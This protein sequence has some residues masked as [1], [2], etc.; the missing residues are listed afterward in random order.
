MGTFWIQKI[1]LRQFLC[2]SMWQQLK[3]QTSRAFFVCFEVF[4]QH[5][6]FSCHREPSPLPK[7]CKFW[8]IHGTR[9]HWAVKAICVPHLLW[10]GTFV[11]NGHLWQHVTLTTVIKRCTTCFI[12]SGLSPLGFEQHTVRMRGELSYWLCLRRGTYKKSNFNSEF[13][14]ARDSQYLIL[15]ANY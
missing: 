4:V 1:S 11:Y 7:G 2:Y 12:D 15:F 5:E 9:G 14:G 8:P 13:H 10:H 6:S 3:K